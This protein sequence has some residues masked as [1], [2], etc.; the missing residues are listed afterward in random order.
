MVGKAFAV[1]IS[2]LQK[3]VRH[4]NA[5]TFFALREHLRRVRFLVFDFVGSGLT[6]HDSVR[7]VRHIRPPGRSFNP[8]H[9]L[10]SQL[11]L[12]SLKE[13]HPQQVFYS[14]QPPHKFPHA[15]QTK[16]NGGSG[17]TN[18]SR[19]SIFRFS[20]I[21]AYSEVLHKGSIYKTLTITPVDTHIRC[22]CGL[23]HRDWNLRRDS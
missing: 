21:P 14:T 13:P 5:T 1:I 2:Y 3:I 20:V 8:P 17:A 15:T 4:Y 6:L 11:Q 23:M 9:L 16:R 19:G 7:I 12:A 22:V 18:A 10:W